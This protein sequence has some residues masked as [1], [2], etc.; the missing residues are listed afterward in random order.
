MKKLLVLFS[1]VII[2]FV[3]LTGQKTDES[4]RWYYNPQ[5]I[6]AQKNGDQLPQATDIGVKSWTTDSRVVYTPQQTLVINPSIRVY[7]SLNQQCEI[8][9]TRDPNN[10]NILYVASQN[11]RG[12]SINAGTY[13][14]TDG[15]NNWYGTDTMAAPSQADQRG[16]PGPAIDKN[17]RFIFTHLTST[18][19]FGSLKGMGSNY[20]TNKG[21]TWSST[22]DVVLDA[23]CD[24][25]LANTDN[26]PSS[27][28]YGNT[29]MAWTSFGTT[30]GNGRFS[31]TTDGG[32]SWST[33][34]VLNA[35]PTGHN[36]QG[37]DVVTGPNGQVYVVWTAGVSSSP[38]T[39]DF[40]GFAKSTNGGLNFTT[41]EN[42]FDANGS[43]SSSF[44]GWGIR[45]NGFP[46]VDCDKT[47]GARNGWIY[48]VT[49][50]INLAP[51][52]T[53]A[54]IIL[55][56]SSDGGTTWSSGIRVNQDALNNGKVQ[57]FPCVRVDEAGGLNVIYYDNRDFPSSGDSATVY[58]SRSL[59]GGTT[60]TDQKIAD[61]NFKPKL[62]PGVNTMGDYI[63]CTSGNGK[64]YA[65]WMDDKN[66]NAST[67]FQTWVGSVTIQLNGLNAFNLQ[68]PAASSRIVTFP[69]STTPVTITWD[70]STITANYKWIFGSPTTGTRRLTIPSG[71]N[72]ITTTLGALDDILAANGF[73]NNGTASD[74][75]VGQWDVW[76]FKAPGAPGVDSL[77]STNG[78]R[79]ITLRRGVPALTA[80]NLVAPVNGTT[81]TTSVFNPTNVDISWT[82]SG[83]GTRYKWLFDA[84]T[85]SGAPIFY[86]PS[87]NTGFDSS[88]SIPNATLDAMLAAQGINPGDSVVGQ[89]RVYAYRSATDSL[90][91]TQTFALTLKR[92]AKGDVIVAY[93]S[94]TANCRISRDSITVNLGRLGVTF[95]LYNRGA[96]TNTSSLSFRGYKKVIWLGEATNFISLVQKDSLKAYLNAGGT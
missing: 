48:V 64:V 89:W 45:T 46:R 69:G 6:A 26:S 53:D 80:F 29:Y 41:T 19:N 87:G 59:D 43:R 94:T 54:D 49:S 30:P 55:N 72:S 74:S 82:R 40:V 14:S 51:A 8:Y 57:F 61:H 92:Q 20:S 11:I 16:D 34:I 62:L 7:P 77:K 85:F 91:S 10:Q 9:M 50:Q 83:S 65:A 3:Y 23:N 67:L 2:G 44:N 28:F 35:T 38:F 75:A 24:K 37:H 13:V 76:A 5:M 70:T 39:E 36:A 33:P 93:D 79:A 95:D 12:S 52:G 88:L 4:P 60:W 27:P 25:N 90:A 32:V 71:S 81:I 58:I 86:I 31:R 47:G 73:T 18:T 66:G 63:G 96:N 1:L 68:T 15:G 42:A 56:R 17:G 78:P 21:V 84:P 22:F